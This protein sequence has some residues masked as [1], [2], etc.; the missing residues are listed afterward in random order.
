LAEAS[1]NAPPPTAAEFADPAR[2]PRVYVHA[3]C[4]KQTRMTEEVVRKFLA[5]PHRFNNWVFCTGCDTY[6]NR[7]ECRW[8]DTGTNVGE[9][10]DRIKAAFPAPPSNPW[11]AYAAP[12][13]LAVLGAVVGGF[14]GERGQW[15]GLFVGLGLGLLFLIARLI[16][17]R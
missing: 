4:G 12:V 7:S 1:P 3:N 13:V 6:V 15:I 8:T 14:I 17:L 5:D 16:G 2:G 11:L 9:Y 10:L